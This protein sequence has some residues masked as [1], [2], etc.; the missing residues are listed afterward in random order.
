[1]SLLSVI[2]NGGTS[3]RP[4][5]IYLCTKDEECDSSTRTC[6]LTHTYQ[7][8][9]ERWSDELYDNKTRVTGGNQHIMFHYSFY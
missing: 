6:R 4:N 5:M 7:T 9:Y 2:A 3:R 8:C 1:M